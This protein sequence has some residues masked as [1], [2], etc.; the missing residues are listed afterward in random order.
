VLE[1]LTSRPPWW[2]QAITHKTRST[3]KIDLSTG[4]AKMLGPCFQ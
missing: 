3:T 2:I 1:R 4:L